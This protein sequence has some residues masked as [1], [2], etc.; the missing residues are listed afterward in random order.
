[1]AFHLG[2]GTVLDQAAQEQFAGR[3]LLCGLLAGQAAAHM[4]Q[5]VPLPG[6]GLQQVGTFAGHRFWCTHWHPPF[7]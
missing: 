2:A 3:S 1:V 7:I 5:E 6:Q 4:A